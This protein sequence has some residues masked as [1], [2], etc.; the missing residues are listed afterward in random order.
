MTVTSPSHAWLSS[1]DLRCHT[2]DR[3]QACS[4]ENCDGDIVYMGCRRSLTIM[5]RA[6]WCSFTSGLCFLVPH[7]AASSPSPSPSRVNGLCTDSAAAIVRTGSSRWNTQ[8]CVR[9]TAR[10][11]PYCPDLWFL[12]CMCEALDAGSA[13]PQLRHIRLVMHGYCTFNVLMRCCCAIVTIHVLLR[14]CCAV[15]TIHVLMRCRTT[16]VSSRY[17]GTGIQGMWL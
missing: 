16:Q 2:V 12:V 1:G 10:N 3:H 7:L 14:C 9:E 4:H 17:R 11:P 13:H 6:S 8:P 15:V 5:Q